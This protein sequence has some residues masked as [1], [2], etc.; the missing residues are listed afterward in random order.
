ME[1]VDNMQEQMGDG[2]KE[3]EI[4]RKYQKEMLEI[5]TLFG[6]DGDMKKR[7]CTFSSHPSTCPFPQNF[8]RVHVGEASVRVVEE[9][10]RSN[11]A[12]QSL[13]LSTRTESSASKLLLSP[14][15][16][17]CAFVRLCYLEN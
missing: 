4:L 17:P 1:K 12:K 9:G 6:K 14:H 10:I 8:F 5:K 11:R 16:L 13:V 15:H 3:I 7:S 2:S